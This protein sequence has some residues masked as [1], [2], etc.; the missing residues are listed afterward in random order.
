MRKYLVFGLLLCIILIATLSG[1]DNARVFAATKD[2]QAIK[3]G[4]VAY[5]KDVNSLLYDELNE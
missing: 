5:F 4:K 2:V 3:N 1:S